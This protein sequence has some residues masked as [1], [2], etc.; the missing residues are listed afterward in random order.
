M[1]MDLSVLEKIGLSNAEIQVYLTLLKL[2]PSPSRRIV[3]ETD[4]RKS[5]VYNSIGRLQERGLV[6]YVIKDSRK[7]FEATKPESLLELVNGMGREIE[8]YKREVSELV[9]KIEESYPDIKPIAEAQ[10]LS[11][12]DGFKTMRRDVL[13]NPGAELL[14]IGAMGRE[15]EAMPE[16][17]KIW[18]NTRVR[19]GISMRIL[20]KKSMGERLKNPKKHLRR[21]FEIRYLPRNIESPAVIN[22]YEDRVVNVIW[23]GGQP[24]CFMMIN[25]E[26]AQ[27]YKEYFEYLWKKARA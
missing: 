2:G 15:I 10:I 22:V 14:L 23:S 12:L 7:Y 11:G 9:S 5:T 24:L 26:L 21:D 16:F 1:K 17:F 27:S 25:E 3:K 8:G 4:F 19:D 13:K 6:S 18:N 20:F